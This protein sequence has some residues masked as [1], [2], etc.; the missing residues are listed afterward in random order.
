VP[1]FYFDV[2][3][4]GRFSPDDEGLEFPD[5]GAAE[6][7]AAMATAAIGRDRL[8][9]GHA[10]EIVMEVRDEHRQLILIITVSMHLE[11]VHLRPDRPR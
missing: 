9:K 8:P 5:L 10:R 1:R 11:R 7:E 4:G 2:R 3:E 6:R